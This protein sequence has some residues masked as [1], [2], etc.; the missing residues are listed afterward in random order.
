[1]CNMK[2]PSPQPLTFGST[3]NQLLLAF[4]AV[5]A[6]ALA[7]FLLRHHALAAPLRLLLVVAPVI[8]SGFYIASLL[9]WIRG[10]DELQRRIHLEAAA[11]SLPMLVLAAML[12][13]SL[14]HAGIPVPLRWGWESIAA[15]LVLFST[16]G[17]WIA[18]RRYR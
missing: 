11:F 8:A 13:S 1:M 6:A 9:E 17:L 18:K 5:L 3:A 10:L 15:A 12:I 7:G 16:V 2:T 4:L 14:P